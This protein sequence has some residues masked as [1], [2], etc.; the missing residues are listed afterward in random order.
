M[1]EEP[2]PHPP[3]DQSEQPAPSPPPGWYPDPR[4]AEQLRWWDGGKWT[5]H[6]APGV[7]PADQS[8]HQPGEAAGAEDQ[9]AGGTSGGNG[10][11]IGGIAL[12]VLAFLFL[13]IVFGP[14][15]IVLG[16]VGRSRGEP[17]A[18]WGLGVPIA[19]LVAGILITIV[20]LS[21]DAGSGNALG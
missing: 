14:I 15:G 16:A 8:G 21:G 1:A 9:H 5:E 18:R 19:G 2:P 4:S 6:T 7:P 17:L 20:A 13:P 12:G 11:S 3:P 10:Y